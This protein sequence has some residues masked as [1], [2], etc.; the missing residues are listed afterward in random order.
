LKDLKTLCIKSHQE[1]SSH[2]ELMTHTCFFEEY[3]QRAVVL[4]IAQ[5]PEANIIMLATGLGPMMVG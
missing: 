5:D 2:L 1:S 3:V 4:D